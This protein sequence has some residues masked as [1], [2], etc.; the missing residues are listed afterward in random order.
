[1]AITGNGK[2]MS[3]N[4]GT[5]SSADTG[6]NQNPGRT[7]LVFI[8]DRSGSMSGLESDTIGGFNGM[9]AKQRALPGEC[10]VTTVL[11]D[12][13][14][15]TLHHHIDLR[16]VRDLTPRDYRAGGSTAL[17]DAVGSTIDRMVDMQRHMAP[18]YRAD[19]VLVVIITDG[20]ENSSRRYSAAQV[21]R[22]IEHEREQYGWEFVFLGANIDAVST[23]DD[24]GIAP[25]C[26]ADFHADGQGVQ[27]S[28][29]AVS[30]AASAVRGG[31]D[32]GSV[33]APRVFDALRRDFRSRSRHARH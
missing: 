9:L 25:E 30:A 18:A 15:K 10:A 5:N 16:A 22:M 32:L 23:A 24:F 28:F 12:N 31:A 3:G 33:E 11:F 2:D 7:E 27:A 6:G 13:R 21:R 20:Y 4:M 17:L 29:A 26:A 1:M 8:V 19:H 14:I